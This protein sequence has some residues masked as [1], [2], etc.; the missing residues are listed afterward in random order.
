MMIFDINSCKQLYLFHLFWSYLTTILIFSIFLI[1]VILK[2]FGLEKTVHDD[3]KDT[4]SA[5]A[6][7]A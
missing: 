7:Q 3:L 2:E 4:A 1:Y 6:M 5:R